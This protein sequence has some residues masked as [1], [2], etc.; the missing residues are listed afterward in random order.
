MINISFANLPHSTAMSYTE[1]YIREHVTEVDWQK[2]ASTPLSDSFIR[3]FIKYLFIYPIELLQ[4]QSMSD[5]LLWELARKRYIKWEKISE[6]GKLSY[7][8]IHSSC[9]DLIFTD[10]IRNVIKKANCE[11]DEHMDPI[12]V[13]WTKVANGDCDYDDELWEKVEKINRNNR[14]P[15]HLRS[16]VG[17]HY[18]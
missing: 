12:M 4:H 6:Y 11:I 1:A 13:V 5:S 16:C 10:N 7:Q 18:Y 2:V 3:E 9:H 15:N 14:R 17:G 8:F